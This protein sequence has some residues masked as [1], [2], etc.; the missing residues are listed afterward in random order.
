MMERS[1]RESS[2]N[3]IYPFISKNFLAGSAEATLTGMRHNNILVG[4][5]WASK[6]MVT[7]F[8]RI[9]T[10]K[11]L[12]YNKRNIVRDRVSVLSKIGFPV[13]LKDLLYRVVF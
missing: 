1:I 2:F 7:K 12:L 4:M 6:F 9:S 10:G 11:H 8:L 3:L 5:I 13:L